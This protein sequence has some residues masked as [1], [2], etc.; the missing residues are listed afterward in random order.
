[1]PAIRRA[2]VSTKLW[3][4]AAVAAAT[5][6]AACGASDVPTKPP[7]S[8]AVA[9]MVISTAGSG[10]RG[11][12]GEV[13]ANPVAVQVVD[14]SFRVVQGQH[15]IRFVVAQGGGSVSDTIV[16]S[17]E[18]GR[19]GVTWVL[20]NTIGQQQLSMTLADAPSS[21]EQRA[22]ALPLDSADRVVISGA[23]SGT[24]GV[25]IQKDDGA[26][27]YTLVWPD[28][29]LA[30]LPRAAEGSWEEVTAFTVGHP[31]VSVLR[32]WTDGVDTVRLAFRPPIEVPITI[33]LTYD[34]DTTAARARHDLAAMDALWET[35]M[36]GLR[37]GRVRFQNAPNLLFVCGQGTPA[38]LDETAINVYYMNYRDGPEDCN[39]RIIRM[40]ANNPFSFSDELQ[41]NLAHEVG[42]ALSLN[43]VA[44]MGN[45]MWP[46]GPGPGS[47]VKTGQI[48]WMHFHNAGA[49]NSVLGIHPV[50]ERDCTV[51]FS[52]CP[53]QTF[54]AW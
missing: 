44:D 7:P 25:L 40:N 35:H 48:Y 32:P 2:I 52:H 45:L 28:T 38:D 31:P 17:D 27:P 50:A 24:I 15:L 43:H 46:I 8:N 53:A 51:P 41:W 20:G 6:M 10:Q 18:S 54:T 39:A 37:V 47:G 42:H 12:V 3:F 1:M 16:L 29:I 30:L 22:Q 21:R 9:S 36:T 13:L 49:L 14:S 19:A 4:V 23:T 34:V 26:V 33:W 5:G 11:F